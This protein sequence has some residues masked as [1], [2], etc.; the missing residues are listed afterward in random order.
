[1][2]R[3]VDE[4]CVVDE[5]DVAEAMVWLLERAKLVVEGAG[6]V[7][8]AALLTAVVLPAAEGS[9]VAVLSGGNVDAGLLS[10]VAQRHETGAG[11]RLRCFTRISDR[12][13]GLAALLTL[14][15]EAGANVRSV[16]HV[17]EAVPLHVRQTGVELVLET[18]GAE[19]ATEILDALARAGYEVE[20]LPPG[21]TADGP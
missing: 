7:G 18:R 15:A 3:S 16:E 13:G 11:R 20:T 8:V 9:T 12:P 10:L 1:V 21:G 19:H 2:R 14:V 4:I 5:D 6:A 17:R